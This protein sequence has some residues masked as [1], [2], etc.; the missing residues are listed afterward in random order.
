M[1]TLYHS[2][3]QLRSTISFYLLIEVTACNYYFRAVEIYSRDA[4][5]KPKAKAGDHCVGAFS[6]CVV[7]QQD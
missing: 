4:G 7:R 3:Q 5:R 2:P 6:S 1:P